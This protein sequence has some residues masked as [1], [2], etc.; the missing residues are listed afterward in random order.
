MPQPPAPQQAPA[1]GFPREC[2]ATTPCPRKGLDTRTALARCQTGYGP[3]CGTDRVAGQ[4]PK[5]D[6]KESHLA[7]QSVASC[8]L[9][10]SGPPA[11]SCVMALV[12]PACPVRSTEG[13]AAVGLRRA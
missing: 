2:D 8:P 12:D 11:L 5:A 1:E 13:R 3:R 6:A 7:V 9:A 10:P 4:T